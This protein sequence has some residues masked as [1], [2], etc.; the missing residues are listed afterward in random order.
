ML[1]ACK[2]YKTILMARLTRS[3]SE[4]C[5]LLSLASSPVATSQTSV[6]CKPIVIA[7]S[8]SNCCK[9]L[10]SLSMT[11]PYCPLPKRNR[12]GN[13]LQLRPRI[14]LTRSE[15]SPSERLHQLQSLR[16]SHKTSSAKGLGVSVEG[17]RSLTHTLNAFIKLPRKRRYLLRPFFWPIGRNHLLTQKPKRQK[18]PTEKPLAQRAIQSKLH[19]VPLRP[20]LKRISVKLIAIRV[21]IVTTLVLAVSSGT[22]STTMYRCQRP[23]ENTVRCGHDRKTESENYFMILVDS[24]RKVKYR[25]FLPYSTFYYLAL[26]LYRTTL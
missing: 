24:C 26:L 20:R 9:Y 10:A 15:S 2:T 18:F 21:D 4:V 13:H 22:H 12:N 6:L 14:G 16:L 3:Y 7:S 19:L 23:N 5:A 1:I 8:A 17:P 11:L 25:Y